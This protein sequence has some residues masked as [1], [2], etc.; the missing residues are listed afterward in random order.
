LAQLVAAGCDVVIL[1]ADIHGFLDN[2]KA[3]LELVQQR[4]KWYEFV[5]RSKLKSVGIATE[6][7]NLTFVLG[8]SYQKTA[9]YVM[10]VYKLSSLISEH[11]AKRAG[12][13]IVKQSDNAPLSGLLYPI[14][15]CL[16]EEYLKCDAQFGGEF[17]SSH[18]H[19][20]LD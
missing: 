9:E 13:E 2:L 17:L 11:D 15:Q 16:D 1:I 4:A 14:L 3:P 6:S 5:I 20:D 7:G 12:A 10:D 19:Y 18:L 8:S